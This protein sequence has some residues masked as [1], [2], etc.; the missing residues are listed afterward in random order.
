MCLY[1]DSKRN[2]LAAINKHDNHDDEGDADF[3]PSSQCLV[4][5]ALIRNC[6][7]TC[8]MSH[9]FVFCIAS[10]TDSKICP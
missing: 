8:L 10:H 4:V 7:L 6:V 1:Y 2:S 3:T 5:C 9:S